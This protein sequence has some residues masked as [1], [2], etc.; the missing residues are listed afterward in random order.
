M[1]TIPNFYRLEYNVANIR[2]YQKFLD[3]PIEFGRGEL[4]LSD[5]PG[6]GVD[7]DVERLRAHAVYARRGE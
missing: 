4:R 2:D 7:L 3:H 1:L 5:R 6:L